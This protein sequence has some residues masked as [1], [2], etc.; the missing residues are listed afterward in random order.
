MA[1]IHACSCPGC[2]NPGTCWCSACKT[3]FY[4]SGTCQTAD[5]SRHKEEC[6][7]HLRKQG[8]T[9]LEKAQRFQREYNWPQTLRYVDLALTKLN[10]LKDRPVE[11]ISGAMSTKFYAL[12]ATGQ[13]RVAFECAKEWYCLWLT[14]HTHPP[15]IRAAFALIESCINNGEYSDARL[16]AHTTWETMTLS[17]DSHIPED[18]HERYVAAGAHCVAK[19]ILALAGSGGIPA[20]E[21][22]E[23]GKEAIARA[24]QALK[25]SSR[26]R[27]ME[28]RTIMN[29]MSTLAQLLNYFSQADDDNE[30]IYLFEQLKAFHT[31]TQGRLSVNVGGTEE[32]L[33]AS[34]YNRARSAHAA[35]DLVRALADLELALPRYREAVRIY[36]AIGRTDLADKA[37][38]DAVQVEAR[39]QPTIAEIAAATATKG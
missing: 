3:T 36:R 30:A 17:R 28:N 31:R 7:R 19:S 14:K 5:W 34:Y 25:I 39:R 13:H 33:G 21:E 20:E 6:E 27:G 26:L 32:Y 10:Q 12:N 38:Q 1:T 29:F 11:V 9:H 16:Y 18:Q 37:A 35:N 24:R 8:I 2:V 4:C 23:A 22:Q 15:A